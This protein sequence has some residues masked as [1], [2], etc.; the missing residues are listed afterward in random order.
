VADGETHCER[1]VMC[2]VANTYRMAQGV[3]V[4]PGAKL[5]DHELDVIVVGDLKRRELIAYYRAIRAQMHSDLPKITRFKAKEI[6]LDARRHLNVHADDQVVGTT[7][8]RITVAP[9]ALKVLVDRL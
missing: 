7:P 2:I 3:P 8:V 6:T 9:E 1:A 5:T 4:A